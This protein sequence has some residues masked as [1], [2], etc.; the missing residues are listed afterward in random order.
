M[1][2]SGQLHASTTTVPVK[3]DLGHY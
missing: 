1:E 2:I 3:R